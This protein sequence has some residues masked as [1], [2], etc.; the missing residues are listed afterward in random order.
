MVQVLKILIHSV[1]K[2]SNAL[3]R[4]LAPDCLGFKGV[5]LMHPHFVSLDKLLL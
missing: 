3:L 2:E 1:K 5:I 4:A